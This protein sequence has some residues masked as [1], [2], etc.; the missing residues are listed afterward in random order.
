MSVK[1]ISQREQSGYFFIPVSKQDADVRPL[2]SLLV[3][4]KPQST[5]L[6]KKKR[7]SSAVHDQWMHCGSIV[8]YVCVC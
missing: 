7:T 3:N 1:L 5:S 8:V 6:Q 4:L 2:L